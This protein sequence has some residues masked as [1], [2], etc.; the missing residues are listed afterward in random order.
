MLKD[1][2][3]IVIHK[4]VSIRH[5]L[6]AQK[7]G[8]DCLSIDGM[9]CAGHPGEDDVPGLILLAKAS[10]A[11]KIPY[12]ASGGFADARGL[13]AALSLGAAG[14]NMG[15]RMMCTQEAPIHNNIKEEMVKASE[16]DTVLMLRSFRNTA[17]IFKNDVAKEVV[18]I[19]SSGKAEFKDVQ[20][21]V[22]GARGRTVYTTGD[23]NAGV[24]SA[25]QAIGLID[26][27]PTCEALMKR[28]ESGAEEIIQS[29]NSLIVNEA[30]L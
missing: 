19:E 2:N 8:V 16:R 28:L 17:R 12:I 1:A 9:E 14:I 11:L 27:I 23:P 15:S 22:S 5:A 30:K 29:M 20:A 24:W 6:S 3:I 4:C 10:K 7:L 25:G 21:L 18:K 13:A 26:D